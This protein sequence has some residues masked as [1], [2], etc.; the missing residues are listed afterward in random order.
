MYLVASERNLHENEATLR[1]WLK[2]PLTFVPLV[3]AGPKKEGV[4]AE[5]GGGAAGVKTGLTGAKADFGAFPPNG[6]GDGAELRPPNEGLVPNVGP[7]NAD[8]TWPN[9]FLVPRLAN[10]DCTG[11]GGEGAAGEVP[12]TLAVDLGG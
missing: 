6:E 1:G 8:V 7:P 12:N 11:A 10:T 3:A 9:S 4:G 5:A 2:I